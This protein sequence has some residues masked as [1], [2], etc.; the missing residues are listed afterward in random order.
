MER[1]I[2]RKLRRTEIIHHKNGV[3]SDNQIENLEI[4][5][6]KEHMK[7]NHPENIR[8]AKRINVFGRCIV[9]GRSDV[10]PD[11]IK[12]C[13]NCYMKKWKAERRLKSRSVSS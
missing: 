12:L 5:T 10:K 2:G 9:C 4:T 11:T 1:H 13:H 8:K 6:Q 3:P 7:I